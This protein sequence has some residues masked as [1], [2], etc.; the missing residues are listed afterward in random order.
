MSKDLRPEHLEFFLSRMREH[1]YVTRIEDISTDEFY[2]YRLFRPDGLPPVIVYL[3]DAY[4]FTD[5]EF[6]ARPTQPRPDYILIAKP[7]ASGLDSKT[8]RKEKVSIGKI[9][10]LMGALNMRNLWQYVPPEDRQS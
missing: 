3:A 5:A 6:L 4:E 10:A 9:G 1:N 7:H 8:Y 2:I